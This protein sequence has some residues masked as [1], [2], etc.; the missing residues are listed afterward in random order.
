MGI[1]V[2]EAMLVHAARSYLCVRRAVVFILELANISGL[3]PTKCT[4]ID[5]IQL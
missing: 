4:H 5:N 1:C 2:G 3:V